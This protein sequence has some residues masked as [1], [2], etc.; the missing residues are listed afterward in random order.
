MM[1]VEGIMNAPP[2]RRYAEPFFLFQRRVGADAY[3][4]WKGLRPSL[5]LVFLFL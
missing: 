3:S 1:E 4:D 5:L 2:E